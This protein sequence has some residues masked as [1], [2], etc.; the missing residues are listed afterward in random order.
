MFHTARKGTITLRC[1]YCTK[2][3]TL[4][5]L[6]NT[7]QRLAKRIVWQPSAS[8][9]TT[10]FMH[11]TCHLPLPVR[12]PLMFFAGFLT[13]SLSNLRVRVISTLDMIESILSA[14]E[15]AGRIWGNSP[16]FPREYAEVFARIAELKKEVHRGL[17]QGKYT[18]DTCLVF[19]GTLQPYREP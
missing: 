10:S 16:H 1:D 2:M 14:A 11:V 19:D 17:V 5:F 9:K 12:S 13:C 4:W 8:Q 18:L 6:P 3:V 15:K 7:A